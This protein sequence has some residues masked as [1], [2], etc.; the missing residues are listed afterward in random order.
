MALRAAALALSRTSAAGLAP[1]APAAFARGFA[2]QGEK[3]TG[4]QPIQTKRPAYDERDVPHTEK[5]LE[6]DAT[7]P[8]DLIAQ[9]PP[10][11][12]K[13]DRVS[14]KS[15]GACMDRYGERAGLGA[16]NTYYQLNSTTYLEPQPLTPNQLEEIYG[17]ITLV[18]NGA[19]LTSAKFGTTA[20][21]ALQ[22]L[23]D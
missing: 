4:G 16:P 9:V 22:L 10:I 19:D 8:I 13:A 14:C 1:R 21:T 20:T 5:W 17:T 3:F 2:N 15:E 7:P 6:A 23:T 12:I 18:R 11:G